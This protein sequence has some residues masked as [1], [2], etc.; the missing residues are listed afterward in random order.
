MCSQNEGLSSGTPLP[1]FLHITLAVL[2][3]TRHRLALQVRKCCEVFL[4]FP[5]LP[6]STAVALMEE[7][8]RKA[9]TITRAAV[10]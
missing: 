9:A 10:K 7:L 6:A 3:S 4:S 2:L 5:R 1:G 8:S